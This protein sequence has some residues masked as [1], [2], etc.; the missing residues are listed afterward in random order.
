MFDWGDAIAFAALLISAG[1]AI[2]RF[3]EWRAKPELHADPDWLAAVGEPIRLN[4]VVGNR[5]RARGG[6]RALL[7][8]PTEKHDPD[9]S[10]SHQPMLARFPVMLEPGDLAQFTFEVKPEEQHT[11][12]QRLLGGGFTHVLLVDQDDKKHPFPIP[13]PPPTA[14]G[15]RRNRYGR[16][17]K[18]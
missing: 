16:V 10:F 9:V 8:S 3:L 15:S 5:G 1:L 4:V 13:L 18:R 17:A 2:L 6:V 11:F 14:E 12:T 7:L